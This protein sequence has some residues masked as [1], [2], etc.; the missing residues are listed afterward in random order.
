MKKLGIIQP[1]KIGDIIICLPIAK[2]YYDHGYEVIWPVD[3]NIIDNFY[4]EGRHNYIPY[5]KFIPIEFDCHIAR[6]IC[7]SYDC[8]T[9]IDVSFTIPG[10]NTGNT[11]YYLNQFEY[12]FDQLKYH[13]TNVPFE[14]K[15]NLDWQRNFKAEQFLF[16]SVCNYDKQIY[17]GHVVVQEQSSDQRVKVDVNNKLFRIDVKPI[18]SSIFD[19]FEVLSTAKRVCLIES[20]IS[21]MLDQIGFMPDDIDMVLLMKH[22]YYGPKLTTSDN[23]RGEPILKSK[24]KKI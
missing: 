19:W 4:Q 22:G 20:S 21:N 14:E 2:W 18:T 8:N 13:I 3:K 15:W 11:H 6:R 23:L 16:D 17:D 5:V 7:V 9:I 10:A 1:G 24:W 12:T